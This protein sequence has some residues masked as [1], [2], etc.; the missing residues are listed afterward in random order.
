MFE[1]A[2]YTF[3]TGSET[4]DKSAQRPDES[5]PMTAPTEADEKTCPNGEA[6]CEGPESDDLPCF[7]CFLDA[8]EENR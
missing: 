2:S 5:D 3:V 8:R 7:A 4:I 1:R 6:W